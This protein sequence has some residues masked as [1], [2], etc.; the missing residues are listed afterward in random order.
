MSGEAHTHVDVK[1]PCKARGDLH[2]SEVGA[3]QAAARHL[4][5]RGALRLR[6]PRTDVL[7]S[8]GCRPREQAKRQGLCFS[9]SG[10]M[11]RR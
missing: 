6:V 9:E 1:K 5:R 11:H 2:G 4:H 7:R 8:E 10:E 3:G